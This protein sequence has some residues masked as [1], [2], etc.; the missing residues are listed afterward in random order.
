MKLPIIRHDYMLHFFYGVMV[1][2]ALFP[3]IGVWS[4]LVATVV[5]VVKEAYD[6][7]TE[8]GH[9]DVYDA[10]WTSF[11]GVVVVLPYLWCML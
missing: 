3:F 10:L 9:T 1:S 2:L 8:T 6:N 4:A 11:G 5:G 7:V